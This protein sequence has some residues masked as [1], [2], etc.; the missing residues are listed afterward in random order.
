[1]L[2][3]ID[4]SNYI[5]RAY[6]AIRR[7]STSRGF[8]TNAIYG[9]TNMLLKFIKEE[10]PEYLGVV[11]DSKGKT[12]RSDIYPA[13]KATR[14]EPP[15][16]LVVQF[17]VIY[18]I[19]DAF[20]VT[21][22]QVE[23][24]EADDIMGTLA[25]KAEEEGHSVVLVTGDKDFC[26][27]VTDRVVLLDT[28]RGK[29]VGV[30]EVVERFGVPPELVVDV[31]A[32]SGDPTDNIPGIRGIG[33]KRASAL[34][35]QWGGIEGIMKNLDRLP[36]RERRLI[37]EGASMLPTYKRLVTIDTNLPIE[38]RLD[39]FRY[40]GFDRYR[41]A[42][43][44]ER[45]EFRS[46][47]VELGM[48][49]SSRGVEPAGVSKEDPIRMDR[50]AL[51]TTREELERVVQRI[52]ET[53]EVSIDLETTSQH[54]MM[55]S[56]VGIALAPSP[57]EAYYVPCAHSGFT[58]GVQLPVSLVLA[59]LKPLLEDERIRKYGQNLKY[60]VILLS[61]SGIDLRGISCDAM[62]AA[63][64]LDSSKLSYSLDALALEMLGHRT[65]KYAD[66]T[67]KGRKKIGFS[68]VPPEQAMLYAGED[69]DVAFHLGRLLLS[70]LDEEGLMDSYL[71]YEIPFIYVLAGMERR[72]VR[73]DS[74]RLRELSREYEK[75]L[76]RI[77]EEIWREA[78]RE[79]NVNSTLQLRE[80]FFS[81]LGLSVKK[82]T[83]TG[84]AS[85]D[86]EV[87]TELAKHHRVPE[88]VLAYRM[89][90]KLKSTYIDALPKLIN[91]R[92]GRVHTSFN[93]VGT[94][95]GRLASSD[96]NLQNIPIKTPEGRTIREAFIPEDGFLMLSAD[97]SQIE[98][99]LLAHFS[100][101]EAMGDAF[102]RGL[103][104]H[105]ETAREILGLSPSEEVTPEMRRLAKSINFGIVYG[106]SPYGLAR[107]LGTTKTVA[108]RYMDE[109]FERYSG[110]KAY[111]GWSIR[112]AREKGYAETILGRRRYIPEL[113][114][115]NSAQRGIGERAA[116]NTPIQGSAADIIKIAMIRI[117]DRLRR[118][119]FRSSMILQV[120]D[121]LLFEVKK[122]ELDEVK[123]IV[124]EEMEGAMALRVPLKVDIGVG[125]NWAEAH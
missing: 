93:Q 88:R 47:I 39:E 46:L 101:D 26:Q 25:R 5:F 94:A 75:E 42:E 120:H 117:D 69:A 52:R 110:V 58:A 105:A 108:K 37:E 113:R 78:G 45:Y 7:L 118:G 65:I 85:T 68:D 71:R 43:L 31:L 23:G 79:F 32:L 54:P 97:Y 12:F 106:I 80:V 34:V 21:S 13:Y 16:D 72:G 53:G 14:P 61:E 70:E 27:L 76:V 59:E 9:F 95:T 11:W 82:L 116:I 49:L 10:K 55:A 51:V 124:V 111:M 17:P 102:R 15:E 90:A 119:G 24:Y 115:K 41:L 35:R 100:N 18:E 50:Y 125:A 6:H 30:R 87:L 22:V 64:L 83:R 29:R 48:R 74:G 4:G 62:L 104:I 107:Q 8:P 86:V 66:L 89:L 84:E 123:R 92:T 91:P 103:D 56:L 3:L 121:E 57:G 28:M 81:D 98:L 36:E 20:S 40:S 60:E 122:E 73:I 112:K 99:R 67:G 77:K 19:V 96:P 38:L 1:M 114:S 2:H 109:Y 63:H 33:E 44:F